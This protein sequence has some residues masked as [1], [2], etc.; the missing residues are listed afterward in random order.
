MINNYNSTLLSIL[1][2][3][4]ATSPRTFSQNEKERLEYFA[5][6]GKLLNH[7]VILFHD[8][9]NKLT[10]SLVIKTE[11]ISNYIFIQ[12]DQGNNWSQYQITTEVIPEYNQNVDDVIEYAKSIEDIF[13]KEPIY[14]LESHPT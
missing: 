2:H 14:E 12:D 4:L 7:I 9:S 3:I 1:H 11:N 6:C 13:N 8:Q 5:S 10:C